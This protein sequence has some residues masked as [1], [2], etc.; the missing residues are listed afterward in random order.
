M[1]TPIIVY[2][3]TTSSRNPIC[4]LFLV[5]KYVS[6]QNKQL[7]SENVYFVVMDTCPQFSFF[8]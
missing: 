1:T 8:V 5:R 3:S 7:D 6:T 4:F 2:Y